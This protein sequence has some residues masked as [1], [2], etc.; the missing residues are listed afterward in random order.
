MQVKWRH[1]HFAAASLAITDQLEHFRSVNKHA[2]GYRKSNGAA[3]G[4]G[5][6]DTKAMRR[7]VNALPQYRLKRNPG[8]LR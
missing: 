2:V 4:T 3:D 7:L 5:E 8:S 6:L 1:A